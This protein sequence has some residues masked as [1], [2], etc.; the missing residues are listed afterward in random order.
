MI[1]SNTLDL[2][3]AQYAMVLDDPQADADAIIEALDWI[4]SSPRHLAAFDRAKSFLAA[5]DHVPEDELLAA[6]PATVPVRPYW[7][8]PAILALAASLALM[9]LSGLLT[10]HFWPR[11][12]PAFTASYA[13]KIGE[14]RTI[15][16]PDQSTVHLAAASSITVRLTDDIRKVD[17]VRGQALFDVA[18][19]PD[20][21]FIVH[22]G[23][24]SATVL[25]T[26][27]NVQRHKQGATVTVV[28]GRVRVGIG[29]SSSAN[30]VVL[31]PGSQVS[32]QGGLL[33]P[34]R[35]VDTD[36]VLAWRDRMLIFTGQPLSEVVE[37]LGAYIPE[38]I[39]IAD[40]RVES[41]PVIGIVHV[42]NVN[43]WI[44]GLG[45]ALGIQVVSVNG[46]IILRASDR[47]RVHSVA[48]R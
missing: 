6:L 37:R 15:I 9:L 5:C 19:N 41:I 46:K 43:Q 23:D 10:L 45:S 29:G 18:R 38:P 42:D 30:S 7:K 16:L 11:S 44:V 17:L 40:R 20:R 35:H 1:G 2:H 26:S 21:P 32:Y 14:Q 34:V 39:V 28:H 47:N 25:G 8:R 3:A 12:S 22:A 13:S 33:Q 24:G 36:I 48:T 27:F 4:N 31:T